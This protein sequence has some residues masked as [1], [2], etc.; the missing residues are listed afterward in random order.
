MSAEGFGVDEQAV[1]NNI[2]R[3][4]P[5]LKVFVLNLFITTS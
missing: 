5:S 3:T 4:T 1:I 2:L